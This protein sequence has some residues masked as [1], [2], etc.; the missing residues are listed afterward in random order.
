MRDSEEALAGELP[1][2]GLKPETDIRGGKSEAPADMPPE[3]MRI[4]KSRKRRTRP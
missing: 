1:G 2:K 3:W 4:W